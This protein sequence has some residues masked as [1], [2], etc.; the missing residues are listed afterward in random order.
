VAGTKLWGTVG[1]ACAIALLGAAPGQAASNTAKLTLSLSGD[2]IV[3]LPPQ[4]RPCDSAGEVPVRARWTDL[5]HAKPLTAKVLRRIPK[6]GHSGS[7][8]QVSGTVDETAAETSYKTC[9]GTPENRNPTPEEQTCTDSRSAGLDHTVNRLLVGQ[10]HTRKGSF[11]SFQLEDNTVAA[12]K[13]IFPVMFTHCNK[14]V[15]GFF[16]EQVGEY[17]IPARR[18]PTSSLFAKRAGN[19]TVNFTG[20]TDPGQADDPQVLR[21]DYRFRIDWRRSGG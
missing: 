8:H 12:E 5:L 17:S 1:T 10:T 13:N 2:S 20:S 18:V 14:D 19:I 21:V 3:D 15:F 7:V 11:T 16:E 4:G 9:E 6:G